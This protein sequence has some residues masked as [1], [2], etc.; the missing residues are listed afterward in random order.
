MKKVPENIPPDSR[1]EQVA[2]RDRQ[3]RFQK[4]TSGN[5]GGRSSKSALMRKKL[6][7]GAGDVVKNILDAAKKGDMAACRLILER[8]IPASK[9]VFQPVAFELDDSD[10]PASARSILRA[11]ADGLLPADQGKLLLDGL[12]CVSRVIEVAELAEKISELEKMLEGSS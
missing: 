2:K 10:L 1:P 11:V 4:G 12:A 3:G 9:P 5:A 7:A 6:E 8:V